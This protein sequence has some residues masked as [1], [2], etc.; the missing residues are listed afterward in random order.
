MSPAPKAP[1]HPNEHYHREIMKTDM[2][3]VSHIEIYSQTLMVFNRIGQLQLAKTLA[4]TLA[5]PKF[6]STW[7]V[8]SF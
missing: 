4:H 6:V 8:S 5:L 3:Q 7:H 2:L 1:R